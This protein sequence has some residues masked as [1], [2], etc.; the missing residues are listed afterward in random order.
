MGTLKETVKWFISKRRFGF[1]E[2]YDKQKDAFVHV[3]ALKTIGIRFLNKGDKFEFD[4]EDGPKACQQLI[5]KNQIS[6]YLKNLKM[7][8]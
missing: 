5:K 7:V 2:R 4:L 8:F 3:T 1:I 6:F